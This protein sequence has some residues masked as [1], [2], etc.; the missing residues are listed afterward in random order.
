MHVKGS[1]L[2]PCAPRKSR[3][4][5]AF[6]LVELLV[7]I[8]VIAV[9][10][11]LLLPV[12]AKAKSQARTTY[13]LNNK[14]QLALAWLMYAQDNRDYLSYNSYSIL[15]LMSGNG[16]PD[17]PNW[18]TS[19]VNWT[20][21]NYSTNLAGLIDDTNSSLAP[22]VAHDAAPYRCP[23]D[24]FLNPAQRA[25]GWSQRD[26][27]VSMNFVMGDGILDGGPK[28]RGA[29]LFFSGMGGD[30]LSGMSH[31]FI[32]IKDL[33]AIGPGMACVFLDEH[34][35]SMYFSPAFAIGFSPNY[36]LWRQLPAS[37]HD[38]GCTFSFADGHE[39][40]KKWLVPQTCV[41]I[42]CTNWVY[43]YSPFPPS[44]D[45]RDWMWFAHHSLEPS[46]FY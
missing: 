25:L 13:C 23:E 36:D 38:G 14:R 18:V 43:T 10:A 5:R 9:L 33:A 44:T 24:T 12:L 41:P 40:Y 15:A 7:V 46:A 22:Y 6:T 20:T 45:L 21:A 37:Y 35:D 26:R 32:R 30:A 3:R 31:Y 19:E 29:G 8:A 39:E 4:A 42:T 27:S 28:S 2:L 1:S 11:A 34:P 17:A 16:M